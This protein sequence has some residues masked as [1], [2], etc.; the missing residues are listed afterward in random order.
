[1]NHV[2]QLKEMFKRVECNNI[3]RDMLIAKHLLG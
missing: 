1:M 2:Y 3:A